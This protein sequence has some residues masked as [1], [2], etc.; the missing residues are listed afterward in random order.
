MAPV[1][2]IA[3]PMLI[4]ILTDL[5]SNREAVEACLASAEQHGAQHYAFLGDLVGYGADPG[6]VLDTVMGYVRRGAVVVRGNHDEAVLQGGAHMHTAARQAIDWTCAQ[7]NPAQ[8][9]FL[10][11]LP[12]AVEHKSCLFVHASAW[13]P[14]H[15][16]YI[17]GT[18]EAVKSMHA[19]RCRITF[20]GHVHEPAL[21][22]LSPTGKC[23]GFTPTPDSSILL[24]T[25]RRWLAIPGSVGQP[26]DGNPAAAYA[27]FDDEQGELTFLRVPYDHE[28]TAKKILGARL[29]PY[30]G[31]RLQLGV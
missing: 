23:A 16:Q 20:C 15:W 29:P 21:Y 9:D 18:L 26:R 2:P 5:H 14:P 4:A 11:D 25:H 24:S 3:Q 31:T 12:Y 30:F 6:W 19:T 27:L 13:N 8:R 22:N 17:T 28:L 7:M 10:R 1:S